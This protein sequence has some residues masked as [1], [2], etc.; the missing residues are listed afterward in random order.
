MVADPSLRARRLAAHGLAGPA[1]GFADPEAVLAR[2]VAVQA[3]DF[4]QA[5]WVLG[6]RVPGGTAG[7]VDAALE[8]RRIVRSWPFRGTLHLVEARLLR[9]ILSL[10][11]ARTLRSAAR[12][13][14]QLEL[15]GAILARADAIAEREL[16]GGASRSRAELLAAWEAE[17]IATGAG[18]GYHL[19]WWL[20]LEA[21]LCCGPV[22]GNGQ[23]FA[24]LDD[25]IGPTPALERDQVLAELAVGYARGHGPVTPADLAWWTGLTLGLAREAVALAGDALVPAPDG[26]FAA[27]DA[28]EPPRT[29]AGAHALAGFDEYFLGYRDRTPV[30]EPAHH[31]R[32][33]PGGNGVFQ[34]V[35]VDG[36]RIVGTWKRAGSARSGD[37]ELRPFESWSAA[38]PERFRPALARWARFTGTPLGDIRVA[39]G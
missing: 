21:R 7:E 37:V 2:L 8:R 13:H 3:Q 34:P 18:R 6:A 14:E 35:L 24:L 17:G 22:E 16:A 27:A 26:R 39:A 10:T 11:A 29:P 31:D 19:I 5:R 9:G 4:G 28:P 12:R 32:V 36:G 25:W 30:C 1:R 38:K 15:D 23:R 33:I 20:A